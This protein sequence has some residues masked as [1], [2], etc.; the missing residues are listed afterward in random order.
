MLYA[1][2]SLDTALWE[3]VL[4]DA[5]LEPVPPRLSRGELERRVVASIHSVR[6]LDLVDLRGRSLLHARV[7]TAVARDRDH[8]AGQRLAPRVHA[9]LPEA[10]GFVYDSRFT[11]DTCVRVFDRA[12]DRLRADDPV[13]LGEFED[14]YDVLDTFR[15]ALDPWVRERHRDLGHRAV[16]AHALNKSGTDVLGSRKNRPHRSLVAEGEPARRRWS[17]TVAFPVRRPE[18]RDRRRRMSEDPGVYRVDSRPTRPTEGN[19][20]VLRAPCRQPMDDARWRRLRAPARAR[21]LEFGWVWSSEGGRRTPSPDG[22]DVV[23]GQPLA[24]LGPTGLGWAL[25]RRR[26]AW[27]AAPDGVVFP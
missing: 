16:R 19:L 2:R 26:V 15:I 1:A 9:D 14:V 20:G 24:A 13:P 8:A 21:L 22:L 17:G 11:A 27:T 25:Q 7:E 12:L 3:A 10:H 5:F 4:R 18:H 6:A 23:L